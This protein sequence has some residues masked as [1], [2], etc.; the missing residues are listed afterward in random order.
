MVFRQI[1][2]MNEGYQFLINFSCAFLCTEV[3]QFVMNK[4]VIL[5]V[6]SLIKYGQLPN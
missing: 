3:G 4:S 6:L 2:D 5:I 1:I